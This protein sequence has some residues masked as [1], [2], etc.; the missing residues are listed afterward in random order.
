MEQ[1]W[2]FSFSAFQRQFFVIWNTK[3]FQFWNSACLSRVHDWTHFLI[4]CTAAR[5]ITVDKKDQSCTYD[6]LYSLYRT[7][8][9]SDSRDWRQ[10]RWGLNRIKSICPSRSLLRSVFCAAS[11]RLLILLILGVCLIR[12]VLYVD[13]DVRAV[14]HL[15]GLILWI[16]KW[17]VRRDLPPVCWGGEHASKHRTISNTFLRL[18]LRRAHQKSAAWQRYWSHICLQIT[19]DLNHRGLVPPGDQM[20]RRV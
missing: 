1:V 12:R 2:C 6:I 17:W 15:D 13:F 18:L 16:S 5:F 3:R 8:N 4:L 10:A 14:L 9:W 19:N 11:T 7:I 20:L